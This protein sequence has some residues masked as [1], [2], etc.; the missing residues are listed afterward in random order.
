M[1]LEVEGLFSLL[2]VYLRVSPHKKKIKFSINTLLGFSFVQHVLSFLATFVMK[3]AKLC[4]ATRVLTR[5]SEIKCKL[6][7]CETEIKKPI[8]QVFTQLVCIYF[9]SSETSFF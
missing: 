7:F 5:A 4:A 8:Y 1:Y 3:N 6:H 9:S 2:Y